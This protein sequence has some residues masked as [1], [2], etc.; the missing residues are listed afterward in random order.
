MNQTAAQAQLFT[1]H[2]NWLRVIDQTK[3]Q[4]QDLQAR[5]EL[6]LPQF[7]HTHLMA[8]VEQFQNRFIRQREVIDEL[9]H[10]IK[11]HE[12]HLERK[13]Q[14]GHLLLLTHITLRDQFNRFYDLYIELER[15]FDE[16][17]A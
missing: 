10:E 6:G 9:R 17:M 7:T 13:D 2:V 11:Q 14:P 3:S 15:D 16:F 12:N 5:L 1:E 8:R 4:F